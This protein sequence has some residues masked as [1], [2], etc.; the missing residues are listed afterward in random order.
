MTKTIEQL[1][2]AYERQAWAVNQG[3]WDRT[4]H[5]VE[6]KLTF[7]QWMRIWTKSGHL[8]ERGRGKGKYCMS[9]KDDLGNYEVGNVFIQTFAQNIRDTFKWR[10]PKVQSK[11]T[12]MKRGATMRLVCVGRSSPNKGRSLSP[13]HKA[14]LSKA[15]WDRQAKKAKPTN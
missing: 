3:K 4:G 7:V 13:E 9:R 2:V 11:S 6:F 15:Y 14:A 10:V 12:R 1:R 5:K 8:E